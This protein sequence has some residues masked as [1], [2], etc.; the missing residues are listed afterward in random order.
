[1]IFMMILVILFGNDY[2]V[3]DLYENNPENKCFTIWSEGYAVTG[4]SS[5]ATYHGSFPGKTFKEAVKNWMKTIQSPDLVN[6]DKL[7]YWGCSLY[8]NEYSARKSFG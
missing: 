6:L 7:T 2:D 3:N 1:M 8:D 4:Q 5:N